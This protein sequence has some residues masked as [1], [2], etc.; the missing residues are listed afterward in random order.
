ML[1]TLIHS[2]R[3][4]YEHSVFLKRIHK[5]WILGKF[6]SLKSKYDRSE[7]ARARIELNE[8]AES[9]VDKVISSCEKNPSVHKAYTNFLRQRKTALDAPLHAVSSGRSM[10]E[11]LGVL[12]IIAVLSVGGIAGYSKAMR[13]HR[14]NIQ[15]EL[16]AQLIANAAN[17]RSNFFTMRTEPSRNVVPFFTAMGL[18]PDGITI[19]NNGRLHDKDGN[20]LQITYGIVTWNN[21]KSSRLEYIMALALQHNSSMLSPGAEEFCKNTVQIAQQN[22][23]DI[24]KITFYT[25]DKGF[26]YSHN[27]IRELSLKDVQDFC[28]WCK[29]AG[30]CHL[31]LYIYP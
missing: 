23:N 28:G 1:W 21:G 20:R 24:E 2:Q 9:G 5:Y 17:L 16:L 25:N 7:A 13:M 22:I 18:I 6:A 15:K 27:Q 31:Y 29:S 10:I 19:D 12:A 30:Y 3:I 4:Q 14:S 8:T 26:G 11:M